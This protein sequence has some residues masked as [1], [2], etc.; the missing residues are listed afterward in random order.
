MTNVGISYQSCYLIKLQ[1]GFPPHP[2]SSYW[3]FDLVKNHRDLYTN[4]TSFAHTT[5]QKSSLLEPLFLKT[6][7]DEGVRG[8]R[9]VKSG[10]EN[11]TRNDVTTIFAA[12]IAPTLHWQGLWLAFAHHGG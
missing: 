8:S 11:S 5:S 10:K 1:E 7:G 4:T 6:M 9:K 2:R 3:I 12:N